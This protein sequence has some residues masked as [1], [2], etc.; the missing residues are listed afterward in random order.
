MAEQTHIK[1]RTAQERYLDELKDTE[2]YQLLR[3]VYVNT[4]SQW[5]DELSD[6]VEKFLDTGIV[7]SKNGRDYFLGR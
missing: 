2:A 4:L 1:N 6:V 3:Y 7:E 5:D